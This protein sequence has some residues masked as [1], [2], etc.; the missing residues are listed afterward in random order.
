MMEQAASFAAL[1][2]GGAA[3]R[4]AAYAELESAVRAPG[5]AE[6][7]ALAVACTQPL[8]AALCAPL[9]KVDVAEFQ[10]ASLLLAEL[11][12]LDAVAVGGAAFC[13]GDGPCSL[14]DIW[15]APDSAFGA[16]RAKAP[17]ERTPED[18]V[19]VACHMAFHPPGWAAGFTAVLADTAMSDGEFLGEFLSRYPFLVVDEDWT[20]VAL[21][22]LDLVREPAG[23]PEMLL[24]G[25]WAAICQLSQHALNAGNSRVGTALFQAG[26]LDVA[27][28]VVQPLS[29]MER[30]SRKHPLATAIW[31]TIKDVAE[32]AQAAGIDVIPHLLEAGMLDMTIRNL[33]AYQLLGDPE[34]T[35]VAG[36]LWGTLFLLEVLVLEAPD[37]AP[38]ISRLRSAGVDAFRFVLDH[39]LA[40]LGE[41]GMETGMHATN[42]AAAV[43]GKDEDGGG[44]SFGQRDVDKV[45][46]VADHHGSVA[47]L[48]PLTARYGRSILNLCISDANKLLLLRCD[49][50][51]R[52]I[53]DSLLLDADHPR[54]AQA[55][56][57][58]VAPPVQR[59]FAEA[60]QQL[61]AFPP[62]RDALLQDPSVTEALRE[63][64][65][66]GLTD[67][68]KECAAGALQALGIWERAEHVVVDEGSRHIMMSYQWDVQETVKRIVA[69]LETR[70]YLLWFD[71]N[72]MYEADEPLVLC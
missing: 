65:D 2:E 4:E 53:V 17:T 41:I 71:L 1:A 5:N 15:V 62:G 32:P 13:P 33:T 47:G 29:P 18:A 60:I 3:E 40:L 12:A 45:I 22:L 70:G 9:A 39:P 46:Q 56:F 37:P 31:C 58:T 36:I 24:V 51:I 26:C 68:A 14:F 8:L 19:T 67:E 50:F 55:D 21:M 44:F 59:D 7:V 38:I 28:A 6:A 48:W 72:N 66:K 57:G 69:E 20:T 42:I 63:L 49:D 11:F 30:I 16:V 34:Q 61:S 64:V 10:R 23:Q 25:A 52:V 43:W 27:L 35:S 54:R